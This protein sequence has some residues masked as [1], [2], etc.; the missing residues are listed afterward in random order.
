MRSLKSL[1]FLF[2]ALTSTLISSAQTTL[3]DKAEITLLT[4]GPG[5]ELYSVF[6][7][8][9]IRVYDPTTRTDI[10]YNFGAFD[11]STPNFYAKFTKGDLQYFV[12]TSSYEDFV[13]TYMHYNRDVFEQVLNLTPVQKQAIADELNNTL[14]DDSKRFYTYEFIH[15]NCT[16]MVADIINKHLEQKISLE[17]PDKGLTYREIIFSRLDNHFFENLGIQITFGAPTDD[18]STVLFLP[19]ELMEG[20]GNT[21]TPRGSL[22]TRR[23]NVYESQEGQPLSWWN[24]YYA[25]GAVCLL[26][27]ASSGKRPVQLGV[28]VLSGFMGLFLCVVML[29]SSHS[30]VLKNYNVALLNPFTLVLL[31]HMIRGN[32]N[33][34][35]KTCRSLLVFIAVYL[36]FMYN[37]PHLFMIL[38]LIVLIGVT[39]FRIMLS[40]KKQLPNN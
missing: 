38:P 11:F 37:K 8:T 39:Y 29:Y 20:V 26:L 19:N 35:I 27:A 25:F 28:V 2:F 4:C 14:L 40:A 21:K 6:G 24:N 15:R 22:E 32:H 5:N 18:T 10:V 36:V 16:T 13:Y 3:S 33:Q 31:F 9:A 1:L 17:N 23:V 30:E 12:T 34:I 7:H